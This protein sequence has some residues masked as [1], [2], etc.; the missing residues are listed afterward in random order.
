MYE[1]ENGKQKTNLIQEWM[2][3]KTTLS[4]SLIWTH[5]MKLHYPMMRNWPFDEKMRGIDSNRG[6]NCKSCR[7]TG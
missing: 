4:Q 6:K 7:W 5:Q 2:I 3:S 1:I